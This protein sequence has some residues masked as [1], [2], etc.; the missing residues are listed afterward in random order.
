MKFEIP[1]KDIMIGPGK[2]FDPSEFSEADV[3][4]R[5]KK[6]YGVIAEVM[7]ISIQGDMVSIEFR[8]ASPEKFNKAMENLQKGVTEPGKEQ[9]LLTGEICT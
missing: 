1:L 9:L 4:E 3:M 5:I 2:R 8:D 6:I 7:N